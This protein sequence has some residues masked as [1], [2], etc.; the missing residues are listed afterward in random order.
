M[1][2]YLITK[3]DGVLRT[4]ALNPF[5]GIRIIHLMPTL[6]QFKDV[7]ATALFNE[8]SEQFAYLGGKVNR[9][10]FHIEFPG[11]S[12]II[13]MPAGNATSQRG[14]GMRAD[15]VTI[16]EADDIL[17]STFDSVVKPWFKEKWSFGIKVLSGTPKRGRFGLLYR[18]YEAGLRG[19]HGHKSVFGTYLDCPEI[20]NVESVESDRWQMPESTFKREYLCDFD[21]AVG[22]IYPMFNE[23]R[24]CCEPHPGQQ[25]DEIL[26]GCDEGFSVAGT[27]VVVGVTGVAGDKTLHV[28]EEVY[29]VGE[30]QSW[31][32]NEARKLQKKYPFA[33]WYYDSAG[34]RSIEEYRRTLHINMQ[35]ADK[36]PGSVIAGIATVADA[37]TIKSRGYDQHGEILRPTLYVDKSKCPMLMKEFGLYRWLLDP[38]RGEETKDEPDKHDDHCMDA[39]RYAI[40]THFGGIDKK[41][42]TSG[43]G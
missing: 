24:H 6:K 43:P 16:D 19:H 39:L 11:G 34:A 4:D 26:I 9:T 5:R 29:Q 3:Y 22:L 1:W 37:L 25:W 27:F 18:S 38:K 35:P 32:I 33:K 41:R 7:N 28:L 40:Y 13:P 10:N 17:I 23:E 31:W 30:T 36:G 14:R 12:T 2:W 15:V 20:V 42:Y 21:S 8:L